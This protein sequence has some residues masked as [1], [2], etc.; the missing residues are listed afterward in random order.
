MT[1]FVNNDGD[2][3]LGDEN[4]VGTNNDARIALMN[5]IADQADDLRQEELADILD[6]GST[7]PF[8]VQRPDGTEEELASEKQPEEQPEETGA[9]EQPEKTFKIKVNGKELELTEAQLIERAQKI[10][11]ADEYLRQ[12][13]E[14]NR[15]A[16]QTQEP[17][18]TGPS[19][20][21]RQRLQDE[22]DLQLV[23]AIQMGTEKE[24]AAA[25]RKLREQTSAKS[26][27]LSR[28]DVSRT[29][30]ERLAFNTAI[31]KFSTDYNDIWSD[32]ILKS[33]ALQRDAQLLEQGDRRPYLDRY[34]EV[35]NNLRA[36]KESLNPKPEASDP[37]ADAGFKAK[38]EKKAA[39]PKVPSA[40]N[41]KTTPQAEEE[42]PDDSPSSV[43]GQ[44]SRQRG[45]PQWMRS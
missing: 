30:D 31:E 25:L 27:S 44:M 10:E 23:R 20:A 26:P 38:E 11:A 37:K 43:I 4:T 40:A 18:D 7:Q 15:L 17:E 34:T 19:P 39:A 24:A 5:Q 9:T 32:P 6:D 45:G 12:A 29:I 21:E 3:G 1:E 42:E 16:Q 14:K 35:G 41:A 8:K 22:E 2:S 28:D 13:A 36:W 33:I